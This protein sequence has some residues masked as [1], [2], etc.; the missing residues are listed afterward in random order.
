MKSGKNNWISPGRRKVA[1]KTIYSTRL[2]WI[3]EDNDVPVANVACDGAH[4]ATANLATSLDMRSALLG[5]SEYMR[6][7]SLLFR[8]LFVADLCFEFESAYFDGSSSFRLHRGF[9]SP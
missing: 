3:F 2:H 4:D 1:N 5:K 6:I 9:G 7:A 8:F